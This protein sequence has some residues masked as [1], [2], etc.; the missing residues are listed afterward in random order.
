MFCFKQTALLLIHWLNLAFLPSTTY[1]YAIIVDLIN[2]SVSTE[3]NSIKSVT[4]NCIIK[5]RRAVVAINVKRKRRANPRNPKKSRARSG[6][7]NPTKVKSL[8]LRQM[9]LQRILIKAEIVNVVIEVK[10]I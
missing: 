5:S 9:A 10:G 4:K 8:Y 7:I 3:N 1:C 2:P 6:R